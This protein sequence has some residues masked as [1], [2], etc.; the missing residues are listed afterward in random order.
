[1]KD[2]LKISLFDNIDARKSASWAE[3]KFG[4][5]WAFRA[6]AVVFAVWHP[7]IW[8]PIPNSGSSRC[9]QAEEASRRHNS[10]LYANMANTV[11]SRATSRLSKEEGT[12]QR[13]FVRGIRRRNKSR[14][15]QGDIGYED[16]C[17]KRR[18]RNRLRSSTYTTE[19]FHIWKTTNEL[20]NLEDVR[21]AVAMISQ[22]KKRANSSGQTGDRDDARK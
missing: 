11:K 13:P 6:V 12:K 17:I 4:T 7:G 1:M 21:V 10:P 2:A 22:S 9:V 14:R 19:Q 3:N 20:Q 5:D 16:L 18:E 8:D 15:V